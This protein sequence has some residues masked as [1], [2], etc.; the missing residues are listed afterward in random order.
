MPVPMTEE[1]L[2]MAMGA[3]CGVGKMLVTFHLSISF[4]IS[5]D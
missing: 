5:M 3:V 4:W 1:P 2:D